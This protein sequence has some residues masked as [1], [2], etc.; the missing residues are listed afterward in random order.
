[1]SDFPKSLCPICQIEAESS[2]Q[3]TGKDRAITWK[4]QCSSCQLRFK[5]VVDYNAFEVAHKFNEYR[6]NKRKEE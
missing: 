3:S 6:K 5:L 1:M 2:S 4:Y